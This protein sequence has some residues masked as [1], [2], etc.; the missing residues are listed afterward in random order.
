MLD[1]RCYLEEN[2]PEAKVLATT[3][4]GTFPFWSTKNPKRI[5]LGIGE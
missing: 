3:F 4:T 1:E 2:S 5:Q